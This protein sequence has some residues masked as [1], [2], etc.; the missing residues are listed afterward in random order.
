M[1]IKKT[2][3]EVKDNENYRTRLVLKVRGRK[4]WIECEGYED[5]YIFDEDVPEGKYSYY[6]R[7]SE[8]NFSLIVGIEQEKGLTVNFWGTIVTD[9]PLTFGDGRFPDELEV[10]RMVDN[11]NNCD[12]IVVF[13]EQAA[14]AYL[15]EGFKAMKRVVDNGD[16][17]LVWRAFRSKGELETYMQGL[18]DQYG[19]NGSVTIDAADVCQHFKTIKKMTE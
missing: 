13:G 16:G 8:S 9:E 4:E 2:Y 14:D 15:D 10:T 3:E 17:M 1:A 5:C 6:C 11:T 19:W 12:A 18:N 7:H